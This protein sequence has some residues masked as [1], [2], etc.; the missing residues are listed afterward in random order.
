MSG[1]LTQ[2]EY[3][4]NDGVKKTTLELNANILDLVGK[5]ND[6]A[7]PANNGYT[8]PAQYQ[9]PPNAS[10]QTPNNGPYDAPY[11]DDIPF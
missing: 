2:S 9:Q 11:D 10:R 7:P 4:G 3:T 5:K 1:E 8:P 6:S